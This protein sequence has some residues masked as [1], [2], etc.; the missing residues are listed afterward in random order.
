MAAPRQG[1]NPLSEI[2]LAAFVII[3]LLILLLEMPDWVINFSISFNI[4]LGIVLL[5][6]SLTATVLQKQPKLS[7]GEYLLLTGE[8]SFI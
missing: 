7:F 3:A 2:A 5:M 1:S 8:F 4:T 6:I